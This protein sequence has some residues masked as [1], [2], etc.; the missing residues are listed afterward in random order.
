MKKKMVIPNG[1]RE[2][3]ISRKPTNILITPEGRR[4]Q[5]EGPQTDLDDSKFG[6]VYKDPTGLKYTVPDPFEFDN[7]EKV[8]AKS[9]RERKVEEM[10]R[11]KQLEEERILNHRF[12]ANSV[13]GIVKTPL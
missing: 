5:T 1:K 3:V 7:R 12:R 4:Y 9:I 8:R 13:P 10:I 2:E 6:A 11:E